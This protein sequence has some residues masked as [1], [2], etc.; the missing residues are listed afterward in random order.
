MCV[1]LQTGD[2]G[3]DIGAQGEPLGYRQEGKSLFHLLQAGRL[4]GETRGNK[5]VI[6]VKAVKL[7]Q[8]IFS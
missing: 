1:A 3:L 6:N 8:N 2:L 7:Q 4:S 5:D